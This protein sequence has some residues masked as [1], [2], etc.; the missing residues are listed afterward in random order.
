MILRRKPSK[1]YLLLIIVLP[2][3]LALAWHQHWMRFAFYLAAGYLDGSSSGTPRLDLASYRVVLEAHPIEG[4][5]ENASGL[6]YN[7]AS[8]TLFVAINRPPA[9]AELSTD[10][11]LLRHIP[12]PMARDLEGITHVEGDLFAVA[13]ESDNEFLWLRVPPSGPAIE[14]VGTVRPSLDFVHRDNLGFEGMSWDE[15]RA[16]LLIANEKRP[17][18]LLT[19]RGLVPGT[20]PTAATGI[21]IHDW[22]PR[23]RF[24]F[25]GRDLA[26]LTTHVPTGNLLVLS[27]E[28]AIVTEYSRDGEVLGMLPLW[29]GLGGLKRTAPQ[30][31]GIAI[32]PDGAIYIISEPNLLYV[33]RKPEP[34][35][36]G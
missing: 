33:F 35:G 3:L 23:S 10:G 9:I 8:G 32:G 7:P 34:A 14:V 19:V 15:S 12:L 27:E 22:S 5:E 6:T 25:L 21:D 1:K 24:G 17:Q 16:E 36:T 20:T 13:D 11:R 4:L 2:G 30:A 18:R 28:S 29:Y 26:S 31:E